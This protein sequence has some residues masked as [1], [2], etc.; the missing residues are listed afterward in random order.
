MRLG[1]PSSSGKQSFRCHRCL[2]VMFIF[3]SY[4]LHFVLD[5]F[6]WNRVLSEIVQTRVFCI[7]I[8]TPFSVDWQN[9]LNNNQSWAYFEELILNIRIVFYIFCTL[10]CPR[11][12]IEFHILYFQWKLNDSLD[13][14]GRCVFLKHWKTTISI[15]KREKSSYIT[16]IALFLRIKIFLYLLRFVHTKLRSWKIQKW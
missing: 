2:N 7:F 12:D 16:E 11:I 15:V 5:T 10:K 6:R 3:N 8:R 4:P 14:R 13:K 9:I 1:L